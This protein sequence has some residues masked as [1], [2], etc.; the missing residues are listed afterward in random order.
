MAGCPGKTAAASLA[1]VMASQVLAR[2]LEKSPTLLSVG[3]KKSGRE[4]RNADGDISETYATAV[5]F[6][7]AHHKENLILTARAGGG[8]LWWEGG[9]LIFRSGAKMATNRDKWRE[10][11]GPRD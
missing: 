10:D 4:I 9:I 2:N 7:W 6:P 5:K 3:A 1:T 11:G 8:N